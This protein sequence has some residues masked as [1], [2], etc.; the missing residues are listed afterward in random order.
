MAAPLQFIQLPLETRWKLS[1]ER[2][3]QGKAH[4]MHGW[5]EY[6]EQRP[7]L[8]TLIERSR[9]DFAFLKG[10]VIDQLTSRAKLAA[11]QEKVNQFRE[12]NHASPE[13]AHEHRAEQEAMGRWLGQYWDD[14]GYEAWAFYP[15]LFKAM[16]MTAFP[17]IEELDSKAGSSFVSLQKLETTQLNFIR[18]MDEH[19]AAA[20]AIDP[21]NSVFIKAALGA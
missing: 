8:P 21:K 17:P 3:K 2:S 11:F 14:A 12:K 18:V 15:E 19:L 7:F 4:F 9:E 6:D 10:Q 1:E 5:G 13:Y 16:V 20:K